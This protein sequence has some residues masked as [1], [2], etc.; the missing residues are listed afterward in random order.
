MCEVKVH[1][2]G[3]GVTRYRWY[4]RAAKHTTQ[5][6]SAAHARLQSPLRTGTARGATRTA[7]PA[8]MLSPFI[9]LVKAECQKHFKVGLGKCI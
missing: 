5:H 4:R 2:G 6:P 9:Q 3:G 7:R 8:I 1:T